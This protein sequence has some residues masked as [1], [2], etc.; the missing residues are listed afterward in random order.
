MA[1]S[2][3]YDEQQIMLSQGWS[4]IS[5]YLQPVDPDVEDIL[6]PII[7]ELI[8]LQNQIGM[9]W[10][11]QGINTLGTWNTH[12]G[13]QIKMSGEIQL[14]IT[15]TVETNTTINLFEGWNLIPV[16]SNC[17]AAD[18]AELFAGTSMVMVR[19]VA[20]TG[21]YWPDFGISTLGKLLPGSAYMVLMETDEDIVFPSCSKAQS[22]GGNGSEEIASGKQLLKEAAG[23][24]GQAEIIPTP[25]IHTIAVPVS[26]FDGIDIAYGDILEAFD[27]NKNCYGLAQ[28]KG[29][30]LSISLFG[31]DQ[32][33]PENDGFGEGNPVSFKLFKTG[34]GEEL[35]LEA[36]YNKLLPDNDGRFVSNG[37]SSITGFKAGP[38]G[39]SG[40]NPA[41]ISIY[42]NPA[43]DKISISY[44]ADTE[45]TLSLYNI[46]GLELMSIT[47]TQATSD[48]NIS[49][50]APGPYLVKIH[51]AESSFVQ[52]LIVK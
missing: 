11:G 50:L 35:L 8:I 7:N 1:I 23:I 49:M 42:P 28:W 14:T 33:S 39:I 5:S 31:D 27:T 12:S 24:S 41:E 30:N 6:A 38:T 3:V 46:H 34:S 21:I 40:I 13:Y 44:H 10:P 15:G 22:I 29:V 48:V 20:G 19:E 2:I 25:N 51:N 36:I 17:G 43:T 16:I 37:I 47:I 18:I 26:A 4:G 9:Y 32:T 45:A 52:R